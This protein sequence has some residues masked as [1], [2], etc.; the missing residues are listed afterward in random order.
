MTRVE[1]GT[2][3]VKMTLRE[4]TQIL[5]GLLQNLIYSTEQL[6]QMQETGRPRH[7]NP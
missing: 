5:N 4:H 3:Q 1:Y 7:R 6:R 2:M